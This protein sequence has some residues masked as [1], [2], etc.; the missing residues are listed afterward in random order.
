MFGWQTSGSSTGMASWLSMTTMTPFAFNCRN[1]A[2]RLSGSDQVE[3]RL[4]IDVAFGKRVEGE[5]DAV[6]GLEVGKGIGGAD[7]LRIGE[8]EIALS[9]GIEGDQARRIGS[10]AGEVVGER[11]NHA[12]DA[13]P[14]PASKS[15]ADIDV[16]HQEPLLSSL[17]SGGLASCTHR[18]I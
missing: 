5:I 12:L 15:V 13:G 4:E 6:L 9:R 7:E 18:R 1:R 2:P 10:L 14:E 11:T 8:R 16:Q 3:V 17:P